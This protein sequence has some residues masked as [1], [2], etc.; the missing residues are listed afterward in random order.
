MK[1]NKKQKEV[2]LFAKNNFFAN[3]EHKDYNV[4]CALEKKGLVCRYEING[5]QIFRTTQKGAKFL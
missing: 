3:N 5:I 4:L 1:I 2:L